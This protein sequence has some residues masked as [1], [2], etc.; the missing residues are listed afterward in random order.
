MVSFRLTVVASVWT[1]EHDRAFVWSDVYL[2]K[3][4]GVSSES[5]SGMASTDISSIFAIGFQK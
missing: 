4:I 3:S 1:G 5:Q 2:G